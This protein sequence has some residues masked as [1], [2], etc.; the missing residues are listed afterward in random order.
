M[1]ALN[2]IMERRYLK[3]SWFVIFFMVFDW[4]PV[5]WDLGARKGNTCV[6]DRGRDPLDKSKEYY[7]HYHRS[8]GFCLIGIFF[9]FIDSRCQRREFLPIWRLG[10]VSTPSHYFVEALERREI[11]RR[12]EQDSR[13]KV[14][15]RG[16]SRVI[17]EL[18]VC[19]LGLAILE[20]LSVAARAD[21]E[22]L[23]RALTRLETPLAVPRRTANE[24]MYFRILIQPVI[25]R[26][27]D[28][29]PNPKLATSGAAEEISKSYL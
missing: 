16:I 29:A 21:D 12:W 13:P 14:R 22:T 4:L 28:P 10:E 17:R 2:E 24:R 15:G 27:I 26:G 8:L 25:A 1:L 23:N 11:C 5:S 19:E 3:N 20:G 18:L 6:R 7:Y 9:I